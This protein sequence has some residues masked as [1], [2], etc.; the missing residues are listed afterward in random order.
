[1]F[2]FSKH[3]FALSGIS[4]RS[5]GASQIVV[6]DPKEAEKC[7]AENDVGVLPQA[8]YCPRSVEIVVAEAFLKAHEQAENLLD[9]DFDLKHVCHVALR[10]ASPTNYADV[11]KAV[12]EIS[13]INNLGISASARKSKAV[14]IEATICKSSTGWGGCS[15]DIFA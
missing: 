14:A 8:V 2:V 9:I 1:M 3:P 10:D 13:A 11:L 12:R 15:I 4:S 6:T 7:Q 5:N